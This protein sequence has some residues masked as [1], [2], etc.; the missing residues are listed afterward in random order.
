M[1]LKKIQKKAMSNFEII[2]YAVLAI[3]VLLIAIVIFTKLAK[4][5]SGSID[6]VSE[7][8]NKQ[9]DECLKN[10]ANCFQAAPLDYYDY[11]IGF[12]SDNDVTKF[13]M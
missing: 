11:D 9:T 10:P 12:I 5:P 13:V 1:R 2:G 7:N 4:S 8:Q 6:K 3:V